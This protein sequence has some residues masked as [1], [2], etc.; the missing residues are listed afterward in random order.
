MDRED[1]PPMFITAPFIN[2]QRSTFSQV[3]PDDF[4]SQPAHMAFSFRCK[5]CVVQSFAIPVSK[6]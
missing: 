2:D 3:L 6:Y 4:R 5:E 1:P